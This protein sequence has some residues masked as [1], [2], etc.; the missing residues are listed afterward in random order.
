LTSLASVF[1]EVRPDT[2]HFSTELKQSLARTREA[3]DV[4]T[5]L[6]TAK[7]KPQLDRLK[8][9]LKSITV[10]KATI[11]AD[12]AKASAQIKALRTEMRGLSEDVKIN[13]DDSQAV[14]RIAEIKTELATLGDARAKLNVDSSLA[15][16]H[17]KALQAQLAVF[18]GKTATADV[19]VRGADGV[20]FMFRGVSNLTTAIVG[21]APVAVPALAAVAAGVGTIGTAALAAGGAAGIWG[22]VMQGALAQYKKDVQAI[23]KLNAG[24]GSDPVK[25]RQIRSQINDI[26]AGWSGAERQFDRLKGSF[27]DAFAALVHASGPATFGVL[28]AGMRGLIGLMPRLSPIINSTGRA[29]AGLVSELTDFT[30]TRRFQSILDFFLTFGPSAI[31]HFGH[32]AGNILLG[33]FNLFAGFAPHGANFLRTFENMSASFARWSAGFGKSGGFQKFMGY[34]QRVLPEVRDLFLNLTEFVGKFI[35]ALGPLAG[36]ELRLVTMFL[37]GLNNL[38]PRVLT[39]LAFAIT[40]VV[41]GLKAWELGT[42]AVTIWN[43]AAKVA[44]VAWAGAQWLLNAAMTANPIGLVVVA[45]A[46]LVGGFILAYRKSETF[47]NIVQGA[48]DGVKNAAAAVTRWFTRSFV[49][50]FTDTIPG[51]FRATVNWVQRRWGD[52]KDLLTGP[53]TAAKDAIGRVVDKVHDIFVTVKNFMLRGFRGEWNLVKGV[54]TGPVQGARDLIG[55]LVDKVH[56]IFVAVK[57]FMM[58]GFRAEWAGVKAVFTGPIQAVVDVFR[59]IFGAGGTVRTLFKNAVS[60]IGGIWGG[61]QGALSG[62][63]NWVIR[64]V[65]NRLVDAVNWVSRKLNKGNILQHFGR[66]GGGGGGGGIASNPG[67]GALNPGFARGGVLPGYTPG[68]DVHTF[69]SATGG[70]LHLSG[71]EAVMRPEWTAAVGGAPAVQRMNDAARRGMR[72][73]GGGVV[74]PTVGRRISTYRG[75]DGV[76]INQPPGPNFGAPIYAYRAGRITYTGWGRGYGDAVFE[77]GNVGPEV[78]YGHMSRVVARRGQAVRA[79]QT[80]G[81]VGA[82]GHASAPHLHFGVPGGTYAGALALLRGATRAPGGGGVGAAL[83]NLFDPLGA[84]KRRLGNLGRGAIPGGD[85]GRDLVGA[86]K[87]KVVDLATGW[88]SRMASTVTA[89]AG[90]ASPAGV[91]QYAPVVRQVLIALGE[92]PG[93]VGTVLR[94]M[95]QESGGRV[96]I[97]NNWDSNARAGHPSTGLMQVIRGTYQTYKPRPDAG[98]YKNGVSINPYSNIYAGLNYARHA[99]PSLAYAMNKRGGYDAGGV[100]R[101]RGV[102]LKNTE[103]PERVLSP[104]QTDTYDRLLPILERLDAGGRGPVRIV[105]DAGGGVTLTGHIDNRIQG[106]Q[107]QAAT[108]GRQR[109]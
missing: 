88:A 7:L 56:D 19:K 70:T 28:N 99:Y 84:L 13:A 77:K 42:K 51:A 66:V 39:A 55:R 92:S 3:V 65:I 25:N 98:P 86:V 81:Y 18:D 30:R 68:K 91:R 14:A 5:T 62:P 78:V 2:S 104:Q 21:L 35:V 58:R 97:V 96:G 87:D 17:V 43:N 72:F 57:N 73:Q 47:R 80:I 71:G 9:D 34:A 16:A 94:R 27:T 10:T 106:R 90:P 46:A 64:N 38:P 102:M 95:N 60:A 52:L 76:D 63:V 83:A 1:V 37:E 49:P 79:G 31:T 59:R 101:G 24:L 93:L 26:M 20:N 61:I 108:V 48:M 74:W 23:S 50:F 45:I 44:S 85:V 89:G 8:A 36:I 100:A 12:S 41:L 15:S 82:T 103:L 11:T 67:R 40:G 69:H 22:G 109:R 33:V 75:H 6:D 32:I 54:F 107:A 105:L 53:I 29:I 4:A